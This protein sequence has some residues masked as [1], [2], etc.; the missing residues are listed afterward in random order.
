MDHNY[1]KIKLKKMDDAL[2]Y[3]PKMRSSIKR[4]V[5]KYLKN[6]TSKYGTSESFSKIALAFPDIRMDYFGTMLRK[7]K[8]KRG[9]MLP[10][11][12]CDKGTIGNDFCNFCLGSGLI[13]KTHF[14]QMNKVLK[15]VM[16]K[17]K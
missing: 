17:D 9:I 2:E 7:I 15:K 12:F 11:L 4:A 13:D 6:Y 16:R 1:Y 3:R 10:C 14:K 5:N 8:L